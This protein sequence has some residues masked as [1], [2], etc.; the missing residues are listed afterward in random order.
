MGS[1][2]RHAKHIV[3]FLVSGHRLGAQYV[4]PFVGGGNLF[5]EIPLPKKWGNDTSKYAVALLVALATG[6]Q[7]P[8]HLTESEYNNLRAAAKGP[9]NGGYDPALIGFAAYCCS[10]AGKEWGGYARGNDAKGKPRNFASEQ[11][12]NLL[13]QYRGLKAW[14]YTNLDYRAMDIEDGATVYCDPP[15][16]KTTSYKSGDFD[17][18]EFWDWCGR[19]AKRDCRVFVSEYA[20]P[21]GWRSVWSRPTTSSLT[22]DT[23]SKNA[24]EQLFTSL[25]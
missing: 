20:A 6:W 25:P 9:R 22:K 17:S 23:G 7:A 8:D 12:R 14:K 13:K 15:Y 10:Y 5:S 21:P 4:E 16:S 24:T 1:K 2:A 11:R 19:L 18:A 3:P